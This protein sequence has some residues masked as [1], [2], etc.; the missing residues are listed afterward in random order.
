[1][2]RQRIRR[3]QEAARFG[4]DEIAGNR[5][6][7]DEPMALVGLGVEDRLIA[8]D[9]REQRSEFR[10]STRTKRRWCGASVPP[11]EPFQHGN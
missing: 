11:A 4:R 6:A 9:M 3:A 8:L 1:M 10:K 5:P 2:K 7:Q